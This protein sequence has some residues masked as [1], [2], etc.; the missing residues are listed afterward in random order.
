M[1]RALVAGFLAVAA[2][3]VAGWFLFKGQPAS[4]PREANGNAQRQ[5]QTSNP[6]EHDFFD[7]DFS[8]KMIVHHQQAIEMTDAI[9]VTSAN[10]TIRE[11]ATSIRQKQSEAEQRYKDW[12][13]EWGETYTNL[14]DFPQMDGHDMYPSYPGLVPAASMSKLK[15]AAGTEADELFVSLITVHH[16]GGIE[17]GEMSRKLQYGKL[18][19]YKNKVFKSYQDDLDRLKL[20]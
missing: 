19:E 7:V 12:L 15:S 6:N 11:L 5:E 18:I 3:G 4:T 10:P 17:I 1:K 9:L 20:L 2:L 14:S 8:R 13:N 16:Q